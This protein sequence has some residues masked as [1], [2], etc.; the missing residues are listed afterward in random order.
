MSRNFNQKKKT[1]C[2]AGDFI[3]NHWSLKLC[4]QIPGLLKNLRKNHYGNDSVFVR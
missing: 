4:V 2:F 1:K 3:Y